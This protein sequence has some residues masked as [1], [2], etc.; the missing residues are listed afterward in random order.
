MMFLPD[1]DDEAQA[2]NDTIDLSR[3]ATLGFDLLF[4][5]NLWHLFI[6]FILLFIYFGLVSSVDGTP[7]RNGGKKA[8]GAA[9]NPEFWNKVGENRTG[10]FQE[11]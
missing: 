10:R 4:F 5:I 9:P 2:A 7:V 1:S 3:S 6:L 11:C 8:V